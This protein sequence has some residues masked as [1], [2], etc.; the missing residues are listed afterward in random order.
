MGTTTLARLCLALVWVMLWAH[1]VTAADTIEVVVKTIQASGNSRYTDPR[2]SSVIE[3]LQS[4]FRYSSY[5][6]LSENTMTLKRGQT[7]EVT[8]PGGRVLSVTPKGTSN[9]RIAL[10]LRIAK[11]KKEIF[12]T[13]VQLLNRGNIIVGGPKHGTGTLLFRI[14]AAQ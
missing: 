9:G 6:L 10:G 3:E 12:Q 4:V 11:A 13:R 8:L 2:L 7:G 1:P 14:F 5:R